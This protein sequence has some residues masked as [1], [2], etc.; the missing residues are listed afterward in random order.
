M[1]SIS[2]LQELADQLTQCLPPPQ[3]PKGIDRVDL[4]NGRWVVAKT[5]MGMFAIRAEYTTTQGEVVMYRQDDEIMGY[6]Q[7]VVAS[8]KF[9]IQVGN[10]HRHYW[11]AV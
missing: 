2:N 10:S 7:A 11:Q 8:L 1:A 5:G 6:P 3:Q 4:M 9:A